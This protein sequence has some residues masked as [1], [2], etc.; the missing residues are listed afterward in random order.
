MFYQF[1]FCQISVVNF[2]IKWF[3]PSCIRYN[4]S[5]VFCF[6]YPTVYILSFTLLLSIGFFFFFF[7]F[8]FRLKV[9]LILIP[10]PCPQNKT[11]KQTNKQT[12]KPPKTTT[13][14][15]KTSL[16]LYSRLLVIPTIFF[17]LLQSF[18]QMTL[19]SNV[20]CTT[21][22]PTLCNSVQLSARVPLLRETFSSKIMYVAINC[23]A[24]KVNVFVEINRQKT[25]LSSCFR[26]H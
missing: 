15:K 1:C 23:Q 21:D 3:F 17:L 25:V 14:K 11:N 20:C 22:T 8:F 12:K 4:L 26:F 19:A 18:E 24:N 9:Q 13:T 6:C 7:F 16:S 2:L 10:T 5:P